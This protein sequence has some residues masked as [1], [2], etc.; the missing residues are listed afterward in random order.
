MIPSIQVD[1]LRVS[2]YPHVSS[3]V[4]FNRLET[5][6]AIK[7]NG[8]RKLVRGRVVPSPGEKNVILTGK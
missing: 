4:F 5:V 6:L 1:R 7:L 8:Q 3:R 2:Y